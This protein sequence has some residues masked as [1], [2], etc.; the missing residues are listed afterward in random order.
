MD[1]DFKI[2]KFV[3]LCLV[4][5]TFNV[6]A[7][8]KI[9]SIC[10]TGGVPGFWFYQ[11]NGAGFD[12]T[13]PLK[14]AN[15]GVKYLQAHNRDYYDNSQLHGGDHCLPMPA[16][17]AAIEICGRNGALPSHCR[18]FLVNV[19][20]AVSVSCHSNDLGLVPHCGWS[21]RTRSR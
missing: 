18:H 12:I 2:I 19:H 20:E 16:E 13:D 17:G 14:P 9:K 8:A 21:T 11:E 7:A 4:C 6:S 10:T 1:F 3:A 15:M 5:I